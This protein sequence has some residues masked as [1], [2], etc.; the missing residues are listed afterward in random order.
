VL[1]RLAAGYERA[2]FV[3]DG[4]SDRCGA[5]RADQVYAKGD[6]LDW[7]RAEGIAARPFG[8]FHEVARAEGLAVDE[9]AASAGD[10]R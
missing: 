10:V 1:A 8:D 6:L 2:V 5:R 4:L 7:C 3:G 9:G